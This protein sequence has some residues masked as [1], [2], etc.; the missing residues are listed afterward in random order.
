[1]ATAYANSSG[2]IIA[3][4]S[5]F[6]L[7]Q[8]FYPSGPPT[9]TSTTLD[10]DQVSNAALAADMEVNTA[11][12]TLMPGPILTKQGNVTPIAVTALTGASANLQSAVTTVASMTPSAIVAAITACLAGTATAAQQ[13]QMIALLLMSSKELMF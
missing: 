1:M 2:H 3:F 9:G 8:E 6:Q 4:L 11:L 10:F 7:V 12:Y 13:Q 5:T